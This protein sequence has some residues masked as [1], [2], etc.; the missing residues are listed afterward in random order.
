MIDELCHRLNTCVTFAIDDIAKTLEDSLIAGAHRASEVVQY[1]GMYRL[2][3][4]RGRRP[5]HRTH[6]RVQ[7]HGRLRSPFSFSAPP[8]DVN[9]GDIDL[10]H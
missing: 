7:M 1:T 6:S 9:S 2:C 8:R 10:L 3:Y 4:I 5:S